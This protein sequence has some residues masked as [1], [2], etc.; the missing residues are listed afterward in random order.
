MKRRMKVAFQGEQGAFSQ[1]AVQ[2]LLGKQVEVVPCQRFEQVFQTLAA[3][4]ADAAAVPIENTL[5]GSVLENYDLLV[6]HQL[7]IV[8][9]TSVRIVHN[10]IAPS[11]VRLSQ[12]RRVY[13]HPVD[14]DRKSVV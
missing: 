11:G 2:Q 5:H 9:E 13:S 3:G 10:L 1:V 14:L 8:A 7:P 4:K 6:E 12:V